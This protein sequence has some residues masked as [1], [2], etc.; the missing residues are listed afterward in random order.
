M[1]KLISTLSVLLLSLGLTVIASAQTILPAPGARTPVITHRQ[2][3][4]QKRIR[5]GIRSDELTRKEVIR[6]EKE[7][8]AIQ[9]EKKEARSDGTV[10]LDE[11]RAITREQNQASRHIFRA[12]HN[13]RDRK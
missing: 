11:R 4:Q 5:Q 12:K 2:Q 6:L 13:H 9:Q 1:K 7:Q 8:R 3:H 10:T